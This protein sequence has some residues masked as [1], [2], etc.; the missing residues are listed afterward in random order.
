MIA[1]I[2]SRRA[3]KHKLDEVS[4]L[5]NTT[6][7]SDG[8]AAL[9]EGTECAIVTGD[10]DILTG[11]GGSSRP[12]TD[13]APKVARLRAAAHSLG[14]YLSQTRP[15]VVHVRGESAMLSAYDLGVHTLVTYTAV[16]TQTK[17]VD[18]VIAR[19][20]RALGVDAD[21]K[22]LIAELGRLLEDI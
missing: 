8:S 17:E 6:A 12:F 21:A 16:S 19:V 10:G 4:R 5:V 14:E 2:R 15:A 13:V 18:A 22:K 20:D 3:I 1:K 7:S 9:F 11:K